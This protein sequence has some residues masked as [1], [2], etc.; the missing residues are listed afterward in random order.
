MGW[1]GF[2]HSKGLIEILG[3]FLSFL[4]L[5]P[6]FSWGTMTLEQEREIGEKVLEEV[7]RRWS[8]VDEPSVN[9]YVTHL[10]RRILQT[11]DSQPFDYQFFVLNT[12]DL[13][14][15][16]VPG[17]KVFLNSGIILAMETEDELAAVISHE[18]GH[19][20]ARHIAKQS[21]KG[22]TLSLATLGTILAGLVLGGKTGAA[23][24]TTGIAAAETAMLKYSR[25]DEL[26]ADYLGLKF[27]ERAGFDRRGM[28]TMLRKM[29]RSIGP[30]SADPPAYLLTHP[31]IEDRISDLE[32]Q[33]ARYPEV[34]QPR[35]S[36]GN[37]R[38]IQTRLMVAEKDVTRADAFF[39]NWVNRS[40]EDAEPWFG[41]G[42]T[43]RR[44]GAMDRAIENLSQAAS[45]SPRDGE[46]HRELGTTYFL[47]GYLDEA[48]KY[49]EEA[50]QLSPDD[51]LTDFYLG[52]VYFEKKKFDPALQAMLRAKDR[53]LGLS[54][55]HYHLAHAYAA[56]NLLGPAYMSFGYH[57]KA[58]GDGRNAL[59]NFQRALPYFP[60]SA[61]E[62]KILLKEIEDLTPQ[63]SKPP[64]KRPR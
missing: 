6:S 49:L 56:K 41:L 45:R 57:Y 27:M 55:L 4:L 22:K 30:A 40:P 32:V 53:G 43:Q 13:N 21:E 26:E 47:K 19:V 64:L 25:D 16:A 11:L 7:K 37:F 5:C 44:M 2:S 46:I 61:P 36:Q 18:I 15:F 51:P 3:I 12:P 31:A 28:L 35:K 34:A 29:R 50:R 39:K 38:R 9:A 23:M 20:V 33:L 58:M 8:I 1:K 63:K 17:G 52:R 54:D 59:A 48:E 14:A 24:A 60:E 42:L 10:G 62:R